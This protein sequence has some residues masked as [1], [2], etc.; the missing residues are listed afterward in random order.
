MSR[1]TAGKTLLT[2]TALW[3]GTGPYVFDWNATHIHN[4]EWPPHAKFHNAQTMSLGAAL[5]GAAL[6]ALWGRGQWSRGRLQVA[7]TAAS[8]YWAT[9]LA[10]SAYPGVAL[11]DPPARPSRKGPQTYVAAGALAL[12]ALAYVVERRRTRG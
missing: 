2:F 7:T 4:P 3:A 12:N 9:Q 5:G 10:A 1:I 11:A 6:T 8:M